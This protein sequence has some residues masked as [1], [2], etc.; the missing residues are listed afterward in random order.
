M[1]PETLHGPFM[2]LAKQARKN[3]VLVQNNL[4]SALPVNGDAPEAEGESIF[5]AQAVPLIIADEVTGVLLVA[6]KGAD[7]ITTNE[8][9]ALI[10]LAA[11]IAISI[12]NARLYEKVRHQ[13][14]VLEERVSQ[15]T[16]EIRH[17]QERIEAILRSVADAV[18]VFD[19]K[20]QVMLTN[21]A[22]RTLFDAHDLEMDLGTRVREMVLPLLSDNYEPSGTTEIFELGAVTLQAKAARVVEGDHA[23]GVVVVMRDISRLRELDRMKD[24][25]VTNVSHELRTPLANLKLYMTLLEQGRPARRAK[26]LDVMHREVERLERLITN[27]LQISR[28][29]RE[30]DAE[31]VPTRVSFDVPNLI[32]TVVQNNLARAVSEGKTLRAEHL[33]PEMPACTGDPDQIVRALTNLV[34][35]ALS[36]T[37]A[38]GEIVVR[39]RLVTQGANAA[40]WV[41]IEVADTGI[42]IPEEELPS[43]FDRFF[44]A[45]NVSPSVAGTGLGLAIVK[46][47]V[48]LH[49]GRIEVES[50]KD[51]GSTF[52]IWLPLQPPPTEQNTAAAKRREVDDP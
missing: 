37:Q 11:Q 36:Y 27:L 48:E 28:L 10:P 1:A 4:S 8:T 44:R 39:S 50:Q 2:Q 30:K 7:S 40:K 3:A 51:V 17:Q 19:L 15:R 43:I 23:L 38:G 34:G 49:G 24:M 25:F 52:R 9:E 14:V 5:C 31:R 35:N 33:T 13:T 18:I 26:Y 46:E 42:G 41:M 47:I 45:S 12:S 20:G 32:E 16:A 6:R 22:A 21:P 29:T